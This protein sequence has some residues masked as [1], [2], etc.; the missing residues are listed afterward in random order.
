[1]TF[2]QTQHAAPAQPAS[3]PPAPQRL[4]FRASGSEYFRI[5]IVNLLLTIVTLGIYSAWAK[6][7]RNRY[8]YSCT[9]LDGSSFEYHGNPAA[10]LKGRIVAAVLVAGYNLA[11]RFSPWAGAAMLALLMAVMP[12]L[13]WKSLQFKLYNTSY[14]GIRF[15]F[16][17]SAGQA[18]AHYLLLP[19]VGV[20]SFGLALPY[21]HQR[22]T[23]FQHSASRF[24]RSPFAFDA[25]AGS[26]YR[27]YAGVVALYIA[28]LFALGALAWLAKAML[29]AFG[30]GTVA[31]ALVLMLPLYGVGF[32]L[33]ALFLCRMHNHIWDH[34][35]LQGQ[36]FHAELRVGRVV[37]LW[38]TNLLGVICT[39]GLF[40]PFAHVRWLK[41][42]LETMSLQTDGSLDQVLADS[43]QQ[44][45][46]AGEGMVDLLDFDLSI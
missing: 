23:R 44:V 31:A 13:Y 21:V 37:M 15:G 20:L 41:Y 26:F 10:I 45:G 5:W 40:M 28:G 35:S 42:R 46:G 1:M 18:Y 9:E 8:F 3:S 32:F 2:Q 33:Y 25:T 4:T 27:K 38:L 14:R 22:V 43:E 6:V 36:R 29:G 39:L 24:G 19:I 30:V 7:R 12:W 17:G 16:G 34:T 11:F